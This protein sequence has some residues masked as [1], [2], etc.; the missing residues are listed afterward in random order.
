M[1]L[2]KVLLDRDKKGQSMIP[3]ERD[4]FEARKKASFKY[5]G[6]IES[7]GYNRDHIYGAES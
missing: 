3:E 5:R 4:W 7:G 1:D 6:R 2:F